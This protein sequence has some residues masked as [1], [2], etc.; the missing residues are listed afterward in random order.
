MKIL[1]RLKIELFNQAY[2]SDEQ[3][4][5]VLV[6]NSLAPTDEYDKATMQKNL[7]FTVIDY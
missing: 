3:Y 6:E 5:Q 4:I 1:D 2:F 7:L